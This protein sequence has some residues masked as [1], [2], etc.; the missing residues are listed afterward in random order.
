MSETNRAFGVADP[1]LAVGLSPVAFYSSAIPFINILRQVGDVQR[2]DGAWSFTVTN[3]DG[4]VETLDYSRLFHSGFLD[5]NGYVRELPE[6][7]FTQISL[8]NDI[9]PEANFGGRYIFTYEGEGDFTLFGDVVVEESV[10]GRVVVEINGDFPTGLRINSVN[11]ENHL[12]NFALVR[13]EHE[14][15]HEAGAIFNPDFIETI[16][17][18]RV[19][20]FMDWLGTNNSNVRDFADLAT[21]DSAFFG[22]PTNQT[23]E[24]ELAGQIA[25]ISSEELAELPRGF[26]QPVFIDPI[27]REPLRDPETN[28]LVLFSPAE[29][30]FID[31]IPTG[32]PLEILVA[33]SNQVGADPWFNIPHAATD[34]FVREFATFVRDNL[35]PDLN[36]V[37]EYSNEVWNSGFDQFHHVNNEGLEFFAE[38]RALGDNFGDQFGDFPANAY[39][40]YRSAEIVSIFREVFGENADRISGTLGTQTVNSFVTENVISG[41]E[42][43][44]ELNAPDTRVDDIFD[45]IGITGYFGANIIRES[46]PGESLANLIELSRREFEAGNTQ[47]Q[48]EFF[49]NSLIDYYRDGTLFPGAL[50]ELS[51]IINFSLQGLADDIAEQQAAING[52]RQFSP[53][54]VGYD[55]DL[56]Q[57]EGGPHIV[58]VTFDPDL[59]EFL[60][61][62][63]RSEQIALLQREALELFREAGGTLAND[64]HEVEFQSFGST[65]GTLAFLGDSNALADVVF[66]F[67]ETAAAQFGSVESGRSSTTFLQ[68]ITALGTASA[69]TFFGT[70]EEDF[71]AGNN[72]DDV[73]IS[74]AGNDGLNGEA[75]NDTLNAGNGNDTLVG[76]TG[77]D[78]LSG[79]AGADLLRGGA[80]TDFAR[81]GDGDDTIE[82]G[83]GNDT[84]V[85]SAGTD[86]L[87]GEEGNDVIFGGV[88]ADVIEGGVGN[89]TINGVT[90]RD[91]IFGQEGDDEIR[92]GGASDFLDGGQGD[93]LVLAAEGDDTVFG[94]AGNDTLTGNSGRDSIA[95]GAGD[96]LIFG[97]S[98]LDTLRG[99]DGDDTIRGE[100]AADLILAGNGNDL[101]LGDEGDDTIFGRGDNDTLF[102]RSGADT[103]FGDEGDDELRGGTNRD[104]LDGGTGNDLLIGGGA[105]DTF[106]FTDDFGNDVI[107]DFTASRD[108]EFIDLSAIS[109]I[110]DFNDLTTNHL[111]SNSDGNAVITVGSNT[112]TLTNVSISD[113]TQSDFIF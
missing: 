89:D 77:A 78:S 67:N 73:V 80:D 95:G 29:G 105:G 6:G 19:L 97:G 23:R 13:E 30:D 104:R 26:I 92:G 18:Y 100:G 46:I 82:G 110:T 62:F 41:A 65:F 7:T 66:D 94:E 72:G 61:Q 4:S 113:L 99:G 49:N 91:T 71:Y 54:T 50:P 107:R 8:F 76:G 96:D 25:S 59:S 83:T 15:L 55:L 87:Y 45:S 90:N 40:G 81:G 88:G 35:D 9:P 37:I 108:D 12:R 36:I 64:F 22:I 79:D 86:Y 14:A 52:F 20:R 31:G 16:E 32:V 58:P 101:V 63:N 68:G 48:F 53:D 27:T 69:D 51:S 43:F 10:P 84:L 57:Y 106:V 47:D 98:N 56:I 5:E 17:D 111:T 103:L 3:D 39:Y 2:Q 70:N 85:G 74:G 21:V 102:G 24:T 109:E 42:Y 112:I 44:L 33:L 28:E 1:S 11:P 38:R 75:G 34:E 93:D 60:R